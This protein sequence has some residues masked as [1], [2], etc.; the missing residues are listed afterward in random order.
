MHLRMS[1]FKIFEVKRN[2]S[3]TKAYPAG[4]KSERK[5]FEENACY[6]D[7]YIT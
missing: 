2:E 3:F 6:T 5:R 4:C 7:T 1:K